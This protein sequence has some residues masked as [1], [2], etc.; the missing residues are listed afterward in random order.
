MV[1][2]HNE[3]RWLQH[4]EGKKHKRKVAIQAL[5]VFKPN[6]IY[7]FFLSSSNPSLIDFNSLNQKILNGLKQGRVSIPSQIFQI[8]ECTKKIL[9][10]VIFSTTSFMEEKTSCDNYGTW[11]YS[12]HIVLQLSSLNQYT[13]LLKK[14]L[15]IFLNE[16]TIKRSM[17]IKIE[18]IVMYGYTTNIHD[19]KCI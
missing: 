11:K 5:I 1:T 17:L 18:K 6:H 7:V 13:K 4:V 19:N 16:V 12:K 9:P 10:T 8:H 14:C 15:H 3:K 2:F